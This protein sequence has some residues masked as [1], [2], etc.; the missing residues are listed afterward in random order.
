MRKR[1]RFTIQFMYYTLYILYFGHFFLG[2]AWHIYSS[3][4]NSKQYISSNYYVV[5]IIEQ[6]CNVQSTFLFLFRFGRTKVF[7]NWCQCHIE[8]DSLRETI[9]I[10]W[11][12]GAQRTATIV[13]VIIY[14]SWQFKDNHTHPWFSGAQRTA[15]IVCVIVYRSWQFKRNHTHPWFSGAQRTA[16]V[17]CVIIYRSW[18]FKG[19]HTHP[20]FSGAQRTATVVCGIIYRSQLEVIS[21]RRMLIK[22]YF[23][24]FI[25]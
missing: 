1:R 15:T 3:V 22:I 16:T 4:N 7:S 5:F 17:V 6:H 25:V 11:F 21:S 13:C 10:Q 2:K 18:Q 19:N 24:K 12:S 9:L 8:A 20:W 14:R 23:A